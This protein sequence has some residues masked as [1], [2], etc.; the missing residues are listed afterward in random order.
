MNILVNEVSGRWHRIPKGETHHLEGDASGYGCRISIRGFATGE[1]GGQSHDLQEMHF[2]KQSR[3]EPC[4]N[5]IKYL[6]CI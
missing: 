3:Q 1:R 6:D 4:I 5:N 2:R